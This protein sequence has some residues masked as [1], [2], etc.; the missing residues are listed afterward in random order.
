MQQTIFV[1]D[2]INLTAE[3]AG[4]PE[5]TPI[6]FMHGGG[7]TRHSWKQAINRAVEHGFQAVTLDLRGHGDSDWAADGD[8]RIDDFVLDARAVIQQIGKPTAIVGASLGGLTGLLVAGEVEP[9]LVRALVLVDIAPKI[10]RTGASAIQAFMQ[11]APDGFGS[12]EEAADAVARYLP[13]RPR[14]EKTD[15]LARN[16]RRGDDGRL[17]WHW[18]PALMR[19]GEKSDPRAQTA[20]FDAAA[21]RLT[22]PTLLVR[23]GLSKVVSDESVASFREKVPSAEVVEVPGADHMVAGDRNDV[24]ADAVFSFLDRHLAK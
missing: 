18:D 4:P 6:L 19:M 13:H 1:G 16:L 3:R 8:Y 10:E 12:L 22:I 2:G 17:R 14:P 23:G 15:G 11:S 5:A 24:F 7:Q 20:R 9:A 21:A